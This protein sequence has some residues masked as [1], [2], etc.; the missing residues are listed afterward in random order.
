MSRILMFNVPG[1]GHVNPTLPVVRELVVRGEQV[2]YYLTDEF[3]PQIHRAGAVFRRIDRSQLGFGPP[4]G[5]NFGGQAD[6]SQMLQRITT[7]FPRMMAD[8]LRQVPRLLDRARAEEA[9]CV[10][11]DPF[12]P[13][14][15]ALAELLGLPAVAF[16]PTY[17][18]TE[19]SPLLRRMSSAFD[20]ELSPA[21]VEAMNDF[22][23]V[24]QQLHDRY[25]LTLLRLTD[26]FARP[27]ALNIVTL[28]RQFQPDAEAL[29][30]R[31]V[32]VGPSLAPRGDTSGFPLN[33][34]AD[35][36][37][38]YVSL[39]T[40]FNANPEFFAAC[41]EAFADSDWQVVLSIGT[42]TDPSMNGGIP[43]NFLVRP[44]VPQLEVLEHTDVFVTHGGMNSAME[45]IYYGVPMVVVP[46][47]PEQA[48]TAARIAELGLGVA[49][50]PEQI[51][52]GALCDAVATVSCDDSYRSRIA[53]MR[54]AAR[55]AGGY[56][57]AADVIQ[58][59]AHQRRPEEG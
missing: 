24:S 56:L 29:D 16:V 28:P 18:I 53:H 54:Q 49:L 27:E 9:D 34:L 26:L 47:Q 36:Q 10:I 37:T 3:E 38:L 15:R 32:F 14:G 31:Y 41:F 11:Y 12:C 59:F 55:D 25:G 1:H 19:Y 8:G 20:G 35:C 57:R 21:A 45:A 39:G 22:R 2:V 46:Q 17:A 33:R 43:D 6:R 58:Q 40:V 5:I 42:R 7:F 44:H 30:E 13:W 23:D 48:M 52:A 50:E 4:S 51:T